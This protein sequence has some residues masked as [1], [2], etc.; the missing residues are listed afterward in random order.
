[1]EYLYD[2]SNIYLD[3]KYKKYIILKNSEKVNL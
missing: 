2:N 1:M 3:R